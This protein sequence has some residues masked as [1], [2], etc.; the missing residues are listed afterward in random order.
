MPLW[1]WPG[2]PGLS[3]YIEISLEKRDTQ[4]FTIANFGHPVPAPTIITGLKN[5]DFFR[6]ANYIFISFIKVFCIS[7]ST[8]LDSLQKF[9]GAAGEFK[10]AL[11]SLISSPVLPQEMSSYFNS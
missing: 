6:E 11:G 3:E 5:Q 10:G 4:N 9:E 2:S 1:I 7:N 8:Y